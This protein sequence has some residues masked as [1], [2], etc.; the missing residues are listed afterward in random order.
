MSATFII[1]ARIT[2]MGIEQRTTICNLRM[3]LVKKEIGNVKSIRLID[4]CSYL[5]SQAI[6]MFFGWFAFYVFA[7]TGVFALSWNTTRRILFRLWF[8]MAV[9]SIFLYM[10]SFWLARTRFA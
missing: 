3:G 9:V 2:I 1:L 4:G 7:Y 8:P 10:C 5:G 6:L